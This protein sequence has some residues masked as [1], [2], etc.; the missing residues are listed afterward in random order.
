M[1]IEIL[2]PRN[3]P[4]GYSS[5]NIMLIKAILFSKGP[6]CEV[7]SGPF[8][9]PLLHWLCKELGRNLVTY[10]EDEQF[11]AF[12]KSFRSRIHTIRLIK[13]WDKMDFQRH[14]GVVL[15]DHIIARRSQDIISFKDTADYIVI[16]D[17]QRKGNKVYKINE[18]SPY[19]KYKFDWM[20]AYPYTSVVSNFY[21]LDKFNKPLSHYF[22]L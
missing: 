13:D 22:K 20:E 9:T 17:S 21:P 12:A 1:K 11:Y 3:K 7:G 10:E 4:K 5:H 16:H 6:V 8:S 2:D 19:F 15:I 18:A 14:W